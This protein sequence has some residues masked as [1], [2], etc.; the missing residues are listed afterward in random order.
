MARR[1]RPVPGVMR[2]LGVLVLLAFA[3]AHAD[4]PA[5]PEAK[6]APEAK[7]APRVL[8]RSLDEVIKPPEPAEKPTVTPS[9]GGG[10]SVGRVIVPPDHPDAQEWPKGM[11]MKPPATNDPMVIA[12]GTDG[13]SPGERIGPPSWSRGFTDTVHAGIDAVLELILL[14]SLGDRS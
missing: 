12:P 4:P 2:S 7:T 11:V 6:P 1:D 13:L 5:K 8:P 10:S 9:F 3:P 14:R